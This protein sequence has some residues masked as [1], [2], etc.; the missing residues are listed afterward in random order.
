VFKFDP[1]NVDGAWTNSTF[2]SP[3]APRAA[4]V[5]VNIDWDWDS[6]KKSQS[7]KALSDE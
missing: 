1:V 3:G 7:M 6:V 2:I 5:G 4:W